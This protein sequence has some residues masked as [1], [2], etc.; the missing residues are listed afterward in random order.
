MD[1]E[2][3]ARVAVLSVGGGIDP[4]DRALA[5]RVWVEDPSNTTA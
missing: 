4:A 5:E 2:A 1:A 3:R